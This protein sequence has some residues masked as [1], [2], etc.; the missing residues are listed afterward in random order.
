[1]DD[2]SLSKCSPGT[3]PYVIK[4]GDTFYNLAQKH[5]ISI[6]DL[7]M[8][9][10]YVNP[11]NLSVGQT[12]CIPRLWSIYSNKKYNVLFHYPSTWRM[13]GEERYEGGDGFFSISGIS[14]S[15]DI[16][17]VCINE[18]S[19]NL[20]PYGENPKIQ[21]LTIEDQ[22]ACLILPSAN[23]PEDMKEQAALIIKYPRPIIISDQEY[24]YFVLWSDKDYIRP[25]GSTL[26]FLEI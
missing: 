7:V 26:R 19:Q 22:D 2:S 12:I 21:K 23:Q 1:L 5:K 6:N 25:I 3:N 10:P 9:N 8:A 14:S 18:A 13:V 20:N 11:Y 16:D 15:D 4:K 24:N 17:T